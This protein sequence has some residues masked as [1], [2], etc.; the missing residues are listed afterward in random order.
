[1]P[2]ANVTI[3]ELLP[4][5]EQ[6]RDEVE[7]SAN[8][9]TRVGQCMIDMLGLI[10]T[11]TYVTLNT[12]QTVS[13][14][15]I[16]NGSILFG[17]SVGCYDPEDGDPG[18]NNWM[19]NIDGSGFFYGTL[20]FFGNLHG[21]MYG[22]T[23]NMH[24]RWYI[25]PDGSSLFDTLIV[26][27]GIYGG[28]GRDPLWSIDPLGNAYFDGDVTVNG[29][30]IGTA[31]NA[32]KLGGKTYAQ[33]MADIDD[34]YVTKEWLREVFRVFDYHGDEV[35]G[36]D[37]EIFGH[38]DVREIQA[39][40][41]FWSNEFVSALGKNDSGSSGGGSAT[42]LRELLDTDIPTS[43]GTGKVLGWNGSKWVPVDALNTT[44]LASYLTSN[45]Y[46]K[47]TDLSSYATKA[48]VDNLING[49]ASVYVKIEWFRKLF[50]AFS[51]SDVEIT[52][53][54]AG[55][56]DN[57]KSLVGLWTESYLSA[58]GQNPDAA[59]GGGASTL[60]ELLDTDIPDNVPV[61]QVLGWDG[62]FWRPYTALD[63]N[64]LANYLNSHGFLVD[65]A[66]REMLSD[67]M[68]TDQALRYA[69]ENYYSKQQVNGFTW[70]GK[71]L[72]NGI[73]RGAM[74]DVTSID[75]FV[76]FSNSRVGI[77]T[78]SPA[79]A[80]HLYGDRNLQV[81]G[82]ILLKRYLFMN[83][84]GEGIYLLNN[85]IHTHNN[86][87]HVASGVAFAQS[88][89]TTWYHEMTVQGLLTATANIKTASYIDIGSI[90]LQYDT[91]N[92][93]LKVVKTDGTAGS[94]YATGGISA[95]GA[96][97][98]GGSSSGGADLSMVWAS[99]RNDDTV[100]YW[101]D[102]S[103]F[104]NYKIA[105]AHLPN[106]I[107][108]Q[109]SINSL[110]SA[111][112][113]KQEAATD[114]L[115][116]TAAAATYLTA[117]DAAYQYLKKTD[118]AATYLTIDNASNT[119]LT[120]NAAASTYLTITNAASTYITLG[121]NQTITGTKT[122]TH[123]INGNLNGTASNAS[124]LEGHASDYFVNRYTAQSVGGRKTFTEATTVDNTLYVSQRMGIGL[125]PNNN[126]SLVTTGSI[127]SNGSL[128][129]VVSVISDGDYRIRT[130]SKSVRMRYDESTNTIWFDGGT[131]TAPVNV[132]TLGGMSALGLSE[133]TA[134]ATLDELVVNL[135]TVGD[136][137]LY[138]TADAPGV[139]R[140]T[141]ATATVYG[142]LRLR[143][144]CFIAGNIHLDADTVA[145]N[146]HIY[147]SGKEIY[148]W[149][150]NA[151]NRTNQTLY[152]LTK[153]TV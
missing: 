96:S 17:S 139:S 89:A 75:G 28:E 58:L 48:Y 71:Q 57:I 114:Y 38:G 100:S 137:S 107:A 46:L 43:I 146:A 1:M 105:L 34:K 68:T 30:L 73:V 110:L 153:T 118:A 7:I 121:T 44:S 141:T 140:F 129:A 24:D 53:N 36:N 128:H 50:Q 26:N 133:G 42:T 77:G 82:R 147:T 152:K 5:L 106:D 87:T 90:R 76:Y 126:H 151:V 119:Y 120:K 47:R 112:L 6:I 41:G 88:G 63:E 115:T 74:T 134:I 10:Q 55:T 98:D 59:S 117:S 62:Q 113:T 22:N 142:T 130:A 132:A 144:S 52:P 39:L 67:Y 138:P 37:I 109:A 91:A 3:E 111:Y 20:Q 27:S 150:G 122:F 66:I 103:P 2:T 149:F 93:Q 83:P 84:E 29:T 9:A 13:A 86:M 123:A 80:L 60:A 18:N 56:V 127:L 94:L 78:S 8:T 95:L 85:V 104:A 61:G 31:T 81:D 35:I 79:Q 23:G 131:D 143:N 108:T 148:V 11:G 69:S 40:Y 102:I 145:N 99:L 135:L 16:F 72:S 4:R 25:H 136:S 15:K 54:A 33:L 32:E 65:T 12:P 45:G 19:L 49:L 21:P 124:Q 64:A 92:G 51:S 125:Q 116:K 14:D 70:W 97:T 101:S